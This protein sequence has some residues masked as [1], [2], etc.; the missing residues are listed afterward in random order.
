MDYS[1][2]HIIEEISKLMPDDNFIGDKVITSG[3][4]YYC[5]VRKRL[6]WDTQVI[7]N[8]VKCDEENLQNVIKKIM[9][10]L[11]EEFRTFTKIDPLIFKYSN[12][13]LLTEVLN[14]VIKHF[15]TSATI[16][17]ILQDVSCK[18]VKKQSG[19]IILTAIPL[20]RIG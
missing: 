11:T 2:S 14:G 12:M 13:D 7:I 19:C 8:A 9:F 4:Q 5:W 16:D 10:Q 3:D 17:D 15:G 20:P 1:K 6:V 18:G